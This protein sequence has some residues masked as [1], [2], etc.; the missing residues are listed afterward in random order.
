MLLVAAFEV[1]YPVRF[2]VEMESDDS[3][4][5]ALK[6]WV[7]LH[8]TIPFVTCTVLRGQP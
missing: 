4:R 3:S 8:R 2:F 1:S 6:L 5:Y 7:G